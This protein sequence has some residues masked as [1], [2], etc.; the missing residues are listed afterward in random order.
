MNSLARHTKAIS[1]KSL[2]SSK[3]AAIYGERLQDRHRP[4]D[5]DD[6]EGA[7]AGQVDR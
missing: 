5:G 2:A 4:L 1:A 7:A 6:P 3:N